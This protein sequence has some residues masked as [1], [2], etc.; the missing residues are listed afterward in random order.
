[1]TVLN[2]EGR[3]VKIELVVTD[4]EVLDVRGLAG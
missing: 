2:G 4:L 1:M 3:G